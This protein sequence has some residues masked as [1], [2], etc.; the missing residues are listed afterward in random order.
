MIVRAR[1][2]TG[3]F[4]IRHDG[5]FRGITRV[6]SSHSSAGRNEFQCSNK[7]KKSYKNHGRLVAGFVIITTRIELRV[8]QRW[9]GVIFFRI[10]QSQIIFHNIKNYN[11][12]KKSFLIKKLL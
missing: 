8:K 7:K 6:C 10:W 12:K 11:N 4:H 5:G 9:R 3:E 1:A 2:Y